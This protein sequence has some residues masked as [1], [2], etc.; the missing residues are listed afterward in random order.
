[1]AGGKHAGDPANENQRGQD[2]AEDFDVQ[3]AISSASAETK[4]ENGTYPY[5]LEVIVT[6]RGGSSA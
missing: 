1:M 4:R 3:F 2:L 5:D 6:P